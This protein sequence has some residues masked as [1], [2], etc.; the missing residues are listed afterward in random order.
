MVD[1]TR[2]NAQEIECRVCGVA[3][4]TGQDD[5]CDGCRAAVISRRQTKCQSLPCR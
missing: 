2:I 5:L 3:S 4:A 1:E